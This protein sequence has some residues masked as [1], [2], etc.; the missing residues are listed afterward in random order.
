MSPNQRHAT[1]PPLIALPG[2]LTPDDDGL[3][4]AGMKVAGGAVGLLSAG[5]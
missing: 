2:A 3:F 1:S 5:F 4:D